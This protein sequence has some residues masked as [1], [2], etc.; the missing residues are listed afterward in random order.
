MMPN[1]S[2]KKSFFWKLLRGPWAA[3]RLA[4]AF[5]LAAK[6]RPH[7]ALSILNRI[8]T[9]FE[10]WHKEFHLL[11]AYVSHRVSEFR[12]TVDD[13]D[14]TIELIA[15]DDESNPDGDYQLLYAVWLKD[16][17]L[18]ALGQPGVTDSRWDD[19]FYELKLDQVSS[20]LLYTSPSPRD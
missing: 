2:R 8:R 4:E 19:K 11:R 14:V 18:R 13:C 7:D 5:D 12:P 1:G 15:A 20:C 3:I 16:L 10:G 9:D 17:S 6:S